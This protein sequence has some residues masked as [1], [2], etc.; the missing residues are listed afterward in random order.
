ML[1]A[2]LMTVFAF[3]PISSNTETTYGNHKDGD[4]E[5]DFSAI[6]HISFFIAACGNDTNK[7]RDD[8]SDLADYYQSQLAKIEKKYAKNNDAYSDAY[9]NLVQ[10]YSEKAIKLYICIEK[11]NKN[12]MADSVDI[13][14]FLA[15]IVY[16]ITALLLFIFAF[17]NLISIIK[18]NHGFFKASVFLMCLLASI[19]PAISFALG[20]SYIAIYGIF[21]MI[22]AFTG[23]VLLTTERFFFNR[24]CIDIKAIVIKV[25]SIVI[26]VLMM[27]FSTSSIM[28]F[29]IEDAKYT[30]GEGAYDYTVGDMKIHFDGIELNEIF[31]LTNITNTFP[32]KPQSHIE[33]YG[34]ENSAQNSF[35]YF[36]EEEIKSGAFDSYTFDSV[37]KIVVSVTGTNTSPV[38]SASYVIAICA[39]ILAGLLL[40]FT[41]MSFAFESQSK[42]HLLINLLNIVFAFLQLAIGIIVVII[43][44]ETLDAIRI[45]TLSFSISMC[46]VFHAILTIANA[47]IQKKSKHI[48]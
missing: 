20:G 41:L 18:G 6:D 26:F 8:L 32:E 34:L 42:S 10:E 36:T 13:I 40:T 1:I 46:T 37:R 3:M 30:K 44:N 28:I 21:S 35:R 4:Y 22:F 12:Y 24:P 45:N 25:V 47:F 7:Y 16:L 29:N 9:E 19:I 38:F 39:C 31:D 23:V 5:Y 11:S 48:M 17:C 33:A 15:A 14:H 27:I 2:L 43:A